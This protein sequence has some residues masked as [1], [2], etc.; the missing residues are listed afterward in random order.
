MLITYLTAGVSLTIVLVLATYL[1]LIAV[2]LTGAMRNVARLADGLE[3]IA[4][5][6]EP[7][8]EKI[9]AIAGVLTSL[10]AG[11]ADVDENLGRAAGAFGG[12]GE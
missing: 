6:T 7:L 9:G 12:R 5:D 1:V 10:E 11:F 2:A 3:G 4:D 8:D